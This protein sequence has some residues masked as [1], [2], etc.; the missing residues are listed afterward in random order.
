MADNRPFKYFDSQTSKFNDDDVKDQIRFQVSRNNVKEP[1]DKGKKKVFNPISLLLVDPTLSSS[2]W[3]KRAQYNKKIADGRRD[4]LTDEEKLLFESKAAEGS[5]FLGK[6]SLKNLVPRD[7]NQEIDA[8][9]DVVTGAVTGPPLA[10]KSLAE[11]LTIGIDYKFDPDFTSKLDGLAREFLDYSGEPETLAGEIT[12]LGTQFLVPMKIVDKVIKS[13]GKLK[14]FVGRTAGMR[15]ANLINKNRFIQY[16]ANIAQRSGTGALS[17]GATDFLISGK[18]RKL[19]PI[20]FARTKEEGK[21]G[22]ELAAARLANK[23][24]FA[25]EGALIGA[26]FPMI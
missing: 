4:L 6:F 18:E 21:T 2:L 7:P 15:N 24:K 12:Q 22:K 26:G 1:I 20:F 13:I 10:V 5:S 23:I 8:V 3:M 14:P 19:D 16:G 9:A 17:L 11:L 25:K